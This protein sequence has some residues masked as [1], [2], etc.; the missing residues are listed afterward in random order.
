MSDR[1]LLHEF[2]TGKSHA[3]FARG[4]RRIQAFIQFGICA[5]VVVAIGLFFI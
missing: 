5:M 4:E 2:M 3:Q 1:H